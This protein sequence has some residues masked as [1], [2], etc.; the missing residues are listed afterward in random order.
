MTR[1]AC[2]LLHPEGKRHRHCYV[3]I[4]EGIELDKYPSQSKDVKKAPPGPEIYRR[5]PAKMAL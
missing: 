5:Y 4:A 2:N 3:Q 1:E